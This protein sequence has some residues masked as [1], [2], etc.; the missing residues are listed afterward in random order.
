[1]LERL[2]WPVYPEAAK[3]AKRL[4]R[5]FCSLRERDLQSDH[6]LDNDLYPDLEH[7]QLLG[8][9]VDCR[10]GGSHIVQI[11]LMEHE[12]VMVK[13][14]KMSRVRCL[15]NIQQSVPIARGLRRVGVDPFKNCTS[16]KL[17]L[18]ILA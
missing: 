12:G 10:F 11:C 14:E 9:T 2:N 5:K 7:R 3:S 1:M 17:A 18:G 13:A 8:Y 15:L 16:G 4:R 6:L